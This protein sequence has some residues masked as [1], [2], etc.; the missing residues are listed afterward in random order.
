MATFLFDQIIFGPVKS[1]RLGLSLGVNLLPSDRKICTFNCIYCECGRNSLLPTEK[2]ILPSRTEVKEKMEGRLLEMQKQ[3]EL[4]DVITFAGNGEPTM[5]PDF[6]GIIN[7]TIEIRNR[8]APNARIAV[9]SNASMLH[10][11]AVVNALR[12]IDDNIL[13]LDSAIEKTIR[14]MDCPVS[15]FKLEKIIE[16]LKAFNGQLVIQTMFLRGKHNGEI[17]DNTTEEELV[18]YTK[19]ISVIR[20]SKV[21]I[22][23]IDRDTPVEGL[24][25]IKRTELESIAKR[26]SSIGIEVQVSA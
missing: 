12:R 18:A 10:K 13:K 3:N 25:K 4:P 9:L 21:M 19:L 24:E 20:P 22:Y 26:I 2:I 5:H 11:A 7:D 8:L 17:I 15:N 1:R 23:S 14:K 16:Q 6:E